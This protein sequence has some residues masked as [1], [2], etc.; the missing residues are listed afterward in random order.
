MHFSVSLKIKSFY[1]ILRKIF[2]TVRAFFDAEESS[3]F[4]FRFTETTGFF[5]GTAV[6][7]G[8]IGFFLSK[9]VLRFSLLAVDGFGLRINFSR[10]LNCSSATIC[11]IATCSPRARRFRSVV[12]IDFVLSGIVSIQK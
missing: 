12:N 6:Y 8:E 10:N 7:K 9:V 1:W 5:S 2:S 4:A 11:V 3:S